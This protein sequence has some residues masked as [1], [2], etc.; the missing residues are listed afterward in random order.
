MFK[1]TFAV[2][3]FLNCSLFI[4]LCKLQSQSKLLGHFAV[5][6][7]IEGRGPGEPGSPLIFKPPAPL[8]LGLDDRFP[9]PPPRSPPYLKVW[10]RHCC[11]LALPMLVYKIWRVNCDKQNWK[12]EKMDQ[13]LKK[14]RWVEVFQ[15][16]LPETGSRYDSRLTTKGEITA[17]L[18]APAQ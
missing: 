13:K 9:P 8:S 1:L 7:R 11:L 18:G 5:R 4:M 6:W 3:V 16:F 10:F 2:N 17:S 14:Q 15:L 12:D